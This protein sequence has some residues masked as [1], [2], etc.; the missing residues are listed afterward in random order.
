M[1]ISSKNNEP[2]HGGSYDSEAIAWKITRCDFCNLLKKF[3][4][5]DGVHVIVSDPLPVPV[6]IWTHPTLRVLHHCPPALKYIRKFQIMYVSN[7]FLR[8]KFERVRESGGKFYW[9]KSGH[10]VRTNTFSHS[11]RFIRNYI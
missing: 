10:S 8:G 2:Q 7:F 3:L 11:F 6:G 4:S 1:T 9:R 5:S